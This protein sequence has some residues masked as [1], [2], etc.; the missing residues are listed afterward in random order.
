MDATGGILTDREFDVLLQSLKKDGL[1]TVEIPCVQTH[2]L[3]SCV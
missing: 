2:G 3:V 1:I